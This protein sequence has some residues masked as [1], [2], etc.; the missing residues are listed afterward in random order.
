M[1]SIKQ[2]ILLGASPILDSY[3]IQSTYIQTSHSIV[4]IMNTALRSRPRILS[5]HVNKLSLC[6]HHLL[7]RRTLASRRAAALGD[8]HDQDEEL[9]AARNWLAKLDAH[10]I[11]RHLCDVSFSRSGGPG[12][13]H[14]NK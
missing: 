6:H 9:T 12:G 14:V 10:T 2:F 11:P 3:R 4:I 8:D 7:P 5:C 1:I 13:Q